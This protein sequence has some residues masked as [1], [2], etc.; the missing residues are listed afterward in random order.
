MGRRVLPGLLVTVAAIAD[1]HG[2]HHLALDAL[3]GAVPFAAVCAIAA[4]GAFLDKRDDAVVA[5][6]ALLWG[7]VLVLLVLSCEVRS[8]ALHGVPP[9]AASSLAAC[10]GIFAI[11]AAFAAPPYLRRL[12]ELRPAKP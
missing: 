5:L 3:L 7:V 12:V 1:G 2:R 9:L 11:K 6:Q 8:N 10:L 4:F